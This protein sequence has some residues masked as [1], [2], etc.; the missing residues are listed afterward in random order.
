MLRQCESGTLK[1]V[2]S[3]VNKPWRKDSVSFFIHSDEG[4]KLIYLTVLMVD[5]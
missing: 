2:I 5:N 4:L 3:K 1:Y